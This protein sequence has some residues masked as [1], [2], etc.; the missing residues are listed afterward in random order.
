MHNFLWQVASCIVMTSGYVSEPPLFCGCSPSCLH[1]PTSFV[2]SSTFRSCHTPCLWWMSP[3]LLA[4]TPVCCP[5]P[6]FI[7]TPD[8]TLFTCQLFYHLISYLKVK[9]A[10]WWPCTYVCMRMCECVCVSMLLTDRRVNFCSETSQLYKPPPRQHS[11][12]MTGS[13]DWLLSGFLS[14]HLQDENML[15]SKFPTQLS[16]PLSR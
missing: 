7:T 3:I 1:P 8:S 12:V 2:T 4:M 9:T 13:W 14:I 11:T 16:I 15:I 10:S 5:N 6:S